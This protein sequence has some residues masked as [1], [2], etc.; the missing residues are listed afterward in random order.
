MA[1][2]IITKHYASPCS[3]PDC[4]CV[5]ADVVFFI[6][7]NTLATDG[8]PYILGMVTSVTALTTGGVDVVISYDDGS[9]PVDFEM[10]LDDGVDQGTV[11]DPDCFNE[12]SWLWKVNKLIGA[13]QNPA[14]IN[15]AHPVYLNTQHVVNNTFDLA[16]IPFDQG[17][18]L[19]A[20]KI[21]C[22]RYD[23]NTTLTATLKVGST[24]I[25]SYTGNLAHMRGLTIAATDLAPDA[26]PTLYISDVASTIY[27]DGALGLVLEMIGILVPD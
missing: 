5:D 3:K 15:R 16:R 10:T 12:G 11:C 26:K 18:R 6:R 23:V 2:H 13:G 17:L 25:G 9:L 7:G 21:T 1:L 19:T 20:L 27:D 8:K 4:I 22:A 14:I 24:V